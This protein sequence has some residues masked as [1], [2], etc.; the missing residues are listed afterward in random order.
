MYDCFCFS[1]K[2]GHCSR[3]ILFYFD[4]I[5]HQQIVICER[6][7]SITYFLCALE[8]MIYSKK[9]DVLAIFDDLY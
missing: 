8:T 5:R 1:Q 9:R 6:F 4:C 3:F 7:V 2:S